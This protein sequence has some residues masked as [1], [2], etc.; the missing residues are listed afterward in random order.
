MELLNFYGGIYVDCDTFP[1]I[2]FS[3]E[4]L[5]NDFFIVKRKTYGGFFIDNFFMG[6]KNDGKIVYNPYD[7][8]KIKTIEHMPQSFIST[9]YLINRKKFF[10]LK[11]K[12]GEFS[13]KPEYIIDHYLKNEWRV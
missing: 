6:K 13:F 11:L 4:L 8:T 3:N 9:R 10:N 1:I 12:D 5:T 2:S 7:I